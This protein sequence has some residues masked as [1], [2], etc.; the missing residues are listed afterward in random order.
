MR[1]PVNLSSEPF[2][3]DRPILIASSLGAVLLAGLLGLLILQIVS[4]RE[5]ARETRVGVVRLTAQLRTITTEEA[6]LDSFL[7]E[8]QNAV[9]LE[10]SL[11]LNQL[12]ERKSISWTRVFSDLEQVMP[13]N[14][15]L[16][17]VRLPQINSRNEVFLDMVVGAKE[18]PAVFGLFKRLEESPLF[19]P[20]E[21]H[22]SLP[23]SQNEPLYRYRLTVNYAQKL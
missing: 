15:A 17:S 12:I 6:K 9:V 5:R 21:V 20:V 11:L 2:R 4:E 19:G 13:Y 8:P 23:P 16:I 14:V 18:P 3:K 10:R 7:R 1:V 22:S